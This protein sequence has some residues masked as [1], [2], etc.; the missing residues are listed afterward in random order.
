MQEHKRAQTQDIAFGE[1][2]KIKLNAGEKHISKCD[3]VICPRVL[4]LTLHPSLH[5][6][7]WATTKGG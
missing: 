5:S 1:K 3:F 7:S 6:A 4:T 2:L